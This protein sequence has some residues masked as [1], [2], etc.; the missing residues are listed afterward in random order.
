MGGGITYYGCLISKFYISITSL[1]KKKG[2]TLLT[3]ELPN[4]LQCPRWTL[5]ILQCVILI[6]QPLSITPLLGFIGK[7]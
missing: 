6:F 5:K 4:N 1:Y 3:F 2:E 7:L